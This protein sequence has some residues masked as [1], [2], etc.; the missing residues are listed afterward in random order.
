MIK[1]THLLLAGA[2]AFAFSDVALAQALPGEATAHHAAFFAEDPAPTALPAPLPAEG[3]VGIGGGVL[4]ALPKP[5]DLPASLFAPPPPPSMGALR[6]DA[7][8]FVPDRLLDSPESPPGWFSGIELQILKPHILNGLSGT[9]RNQAQRANRTSTTVALPSAPL[10]WAVSPRVFLGYRLP[11]GF[12]EFMVAYR[13]LGT[14]GRGSLPGAQGTS[15]LNSRLAFDMIDFDYNSREYSLGPDWDMKWTLGIR[16]LF[17]FFDSRLSAPIGQSATYNGIFQARQYN[18]IA[19]AGPHAALDLVRHL[20]DTGW[21]LDF[22]A[23]FASVFEGSHVGF[24]TRSTT[25]GPDGRPLPG[26]TRRF[27][28]Q[29]SPILNVRAGATWQPS[30]HSATRFFLGYQYERFWALDSL[31]STANTPPSVGQLWQQG[32]VLQATFNY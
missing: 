18:N 6:V 28:T 8:Y 13:H 11:S 14:E 19:G 23:D 12:G 25:L 29:D 24:L 5:G 31:P 10:D 27:G 2:V 30:P 17:M 16:S 21:S 26:E 3:D 15:T 4:E 9:V 32:I 22:R 1:M 7:P 20:G